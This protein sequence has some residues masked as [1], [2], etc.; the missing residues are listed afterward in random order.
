MIPCVAKTGN[1]ETLGQRFGAFQTAV[2]LSY[3]PIELLEASPSL[4]Y[5]RCLT[6]LP[7]AGTILARQSNN[8]FLG[9]Q[10]FAMSSVF[11]G[12]TMILVSTF[13]CGRIARTWKV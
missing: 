11:I 1:I 12:T 9:L 10:M 3:V 6:G 4:R 5:S 13:L 7:I 8:G 2:A